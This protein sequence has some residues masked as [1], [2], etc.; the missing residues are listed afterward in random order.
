MRLMKNKN[1]FY[2][3]SCTKTE[4]AQGHSPN[5]KIPC[6]H[7]NVTS[8]NKDLRPPKERIEPNCENCGRRK[9]VTRKELWE[10]HNPASWRSWMMAQSK[11]NQRRK[12]W[13]KRQVELEIQRLAT[14]ENPDFS[15]V[16]E[17]SSK[18]VE[19]SI[20]ENLNQKPW[21]SEANAEVLEQ[22]ADALEIVTSKEGEF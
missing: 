2:G 4:S 19:A 1:W 21:A 17:D 15:Y 11:Y 20:S 5:D 22:I 9:S 14:L 13:R 12:D 8:S 10:P 16:E 6:G 18:S 7:P 3:W